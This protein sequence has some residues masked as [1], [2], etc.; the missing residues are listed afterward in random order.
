MKFIR[1]PQEAFVENLRTNT[2]LVR[3]IV[4]NENL[5]IESIKVGDISKTECAICYLSDITNSDLVAEVKYRINNLSVDSI[6]SSR[7]IRTINFRNK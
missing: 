6:L 5:I 3:K 1:G 4:N 2:S 7:S